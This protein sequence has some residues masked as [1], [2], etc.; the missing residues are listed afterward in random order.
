M[1]AFNV[2]FPAPEVIL[3][4]DKSF[5]HLISPPPWASRSL[6]PKLGAGGGGGGTAK[7]LVEMRSLGCQLMDV[8]DTCRNSAKPP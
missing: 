4:G 2:V 6:N 1:V 8:T 7:R 5:P 3:S